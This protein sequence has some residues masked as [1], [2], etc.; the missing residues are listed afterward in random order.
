MKNISV[1]TKVTIISVV[2][3]LAFCVVYFIFSHNKDDEKMGTAALSSNDSVTTAD[4]WN[5]GSFSNIIVNPAGSI[6]IDDLTLDYNE[7]DLRAI[8]AQNPLR[9][10]ANAS[11]SEVGEVVDG[12]LSTAWNVYCAA[13]CGYQPYWQLDLG[14]NYDLAAFE[15]DHGG[16]A[17]IE[18]SLNGVDWFTFSNANAGPGDWGVPIPAPLGVKTARY[19]RIIEDIEWE[20]IALGEFKL[21]TA[22]STA[23]HTTAPTQIDGQEGSADKTLIEWETF[24]PTQ[25]TPANTSITYEFRTSA[26]GADWTS[27]SAPQTY[28]GSPLDL[29]TLIPNRYLQVRSTLTTSDPLATPR[30]DDYTIN[31]HNNLPPNAPTAETVIIGE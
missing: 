2:L 4:D 14:A 24:T 7:I 6:S 12:N 31:F 3:F 5:L 19:V 26:N 8:Y 18:Y 9:A 1:A 29:T 28:S 21:Y 22:N 30:I 10:T 13:P 15:L 27:W 17:N 11:Q 25:T 20:N 23:T 16:V